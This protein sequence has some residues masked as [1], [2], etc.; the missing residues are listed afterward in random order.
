MKS[1]LKSVTV[2]LLAQNTYFRCSFHFCTM[3]TLKVTLKQISSTE[4]NKRP[5]AIL[6]KAQTEPVEITSRGESIVVML[7]LQQYQAMGGERFRLLKQLEKNHRQAKASGLTQK[8]LQQVFTHAEQPE[9]QGAKIARILGES[10]FLGNGAGD[11]LR[12]Y[13]RDFRDTFELR[14]PLDV[15]VSS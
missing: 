7:P 10:N 1:Y 13:V 15:D 12:G 14:S 2:K 5:G 11:E 8:T 4:L 9:S 3:V 6:R